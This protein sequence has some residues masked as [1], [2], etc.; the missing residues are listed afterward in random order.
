[1]KILQLCYKMPFPQKDGGASSI[2]HTAVGLMNNKIDLKILAINTP[3]NWVE[4]DSVPLQFR[5]ATRFEYSIVDTRIKISHCL[6]NLFTRQSYFVSRFYAK[7][8]ES[9]LIKILQQEEFDI[10]QLE[11]VYMGVYLDAIRK[12]SK[13]KIILRAQNVEFNLWTRISDSKINL[14]KKL[15]LKMATHRL[16]KFETQI[17]QKVDGIMAISKEDESTFS[18]IAP[19]VALKSI[20]MGWDFNKTKSL[21]NDSHNNDFPVFYHLGS[22]DWLPNIEG[23]KWFIETIVPAIHLKYPHFQFRLAGK[24]MPAWFYEKQN[25]NL[26]IDGEVE[27]SLEYQMNKSILI[28]PLLSGGGMRVKIIEGMAL[29]KTIISTS[30][31]AEGIPYTDQENILIAD[32]RE[33]FL[34]QISQCIESIDF[35]KKIGANAK[36]LAKE[37]FD[38]TNVGREMIFFYESV[39]LKK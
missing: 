20:P 6:L 13:A 27:S 38:C 23:L 10:I 1:M 32:S 34:V 4:I 5:E 14:L 26:I 37:N 28:V 9:H 36:K 22:M 3:K 39:T 11:H 16:R 15:Y 21:N 2:Y 25:K 30:I 33:D 24:K 35:C 19:D 31:G 29:G 12:Y 18:K 7:S 17:S 8:H